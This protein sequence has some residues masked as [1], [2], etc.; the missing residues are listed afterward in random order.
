MKSLKKEML[1]HKRI[2]GNIKF[3]WDSWGDV[4]R[5]GC[6]RS[7]PFPNM[8]VEAGEVTSSMLMW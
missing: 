2:W 1:Q 5:A 8:L 3:D 6:I 7:Q 4:A